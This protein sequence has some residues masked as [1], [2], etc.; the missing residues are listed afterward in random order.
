MATIHQL[1]T[2]AADYLS[3][4]G[5]E[6]PREDAELIVA[7]VTRTSRT[8]LM[9][10]PEESLSSA[11]TVLAWRWLKKRAGH[12]PIQYLRGQQEFYGYEFLV[13]PNVLVPRPETELLVDVSLE[14][15]RD[16]KPPC[17]V[18]D[19]GTGSGCIAISLLSEL[20]ELAVVATDIS[21]SALAVARA[22]ACRNACGDR[23]RLMCGDV[24]GP[25]LT[26]PDGFDLVVSN[27]PY[28]AER[29][30]HLV[31]TSVAEFEPAGAVFAG[32]SGLEVIERLFEQVP[33]VLK[34]DGFLVLELACGRDPAIS[35]LG[36]AHRWVQVDLRRDLAGINRCAVFRP[37]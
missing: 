6:S 11:D 3:S 26:H 10:H 19:I 32:K 5:L 2:S 35:A 27:P 30:R 18:L 8:Y 16:R 17:T 37:G 21:E 20:P 36:R 15:L 23:L 28:V 25:I 1:L 29:D 34:S 24:A 33:A 13:T 22:N 12:Y 14:F 7:T 9:S 4:S 31:S